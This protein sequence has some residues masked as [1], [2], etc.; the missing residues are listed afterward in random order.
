MFVTTVISYQKAWDTLM[1]D[2]ESPLAD[3]NYALEMFNADNLS[4]RHVTKIFRGNSD[5]QPILTASLPLALTYFLSRKKWKTLPD[6]DSY[7]EF[8]P[9]GIKN[10]I[11]KGGACVKLIST[12]K[13][14][15]FSNWLIYETPIIY[16]SGVSKVCVLLVPERDV[17]VIVQD[18]DKLFTLEKSRELLRKLS[19]L[20]SNAPFAILGFS[21]KKQ[22][23]EPDIYEIQP[24]ERSLHSNTI[25]VVRSIEFSEAYLNSGIRILSEFCEH[26]RKLHPNDD[27]KVKIEQRGL[28]VNL[29]VD[30]FG[31]DPVKISKALNDYGN[32]ISEARGSCANYPGDGMSKELLRTLQMALQNRQSQNVHV[33]ANAESSAKSVIKINQ[34]VSGVLGS[35]NEILDAL[36]MSSKMK[37]ELQ[38]IRSGLSKLENIQEPVEVRT[39]G[40]MNRLRRL[41][42]GLN[43]GNSSIRKALESV[44]SSFELARDLGEK[45]NKLADWCGM[46][47]IPK[48]FFKST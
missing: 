13:E 28:Q 11:F 40:S 12:Y 30:T 1:A 22:Q 47:Q 4:K 5:G 21:I 19:P 37:S 7:Q 6:L 20:K 32:E 42:E 27:V 45:Y 33:I 26:L 31:S 16:C 15:H 34:N 2:S 3:I 36:G 23:F 10:L 18:K 43:D 44:E 41:V 39:S 8:K 35:I 25:S 9:F 24:S 48:F 38:E 46:P 17:S 14:S 29:I